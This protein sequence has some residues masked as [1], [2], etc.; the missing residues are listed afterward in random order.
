M[1]SN[2]PPIVRWGVSLSKLARQAA[3]GLGSRVC[4]SR[5]V[6]SRVWTVIADSAVTYAFHSELPESPFS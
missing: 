2:A 6:G 3:S 4:C 1:A 5:V